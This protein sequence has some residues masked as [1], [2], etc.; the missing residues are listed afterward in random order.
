MFEIYLDV[1]EN[2]NLDTYRAN[3]VSSFLF[4][5]QCSQNNGHLIFSLL[6]VLKSYNVQRTN[7]LSISIF[8]YSDCDI[9]FLSKCLEYS[10]GPQKV[11]KIFL[12]EYVYRFQLR[13][14]FINHITNFINISHD[15]YLALHVFALN[16][17]TTRQ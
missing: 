9:Y 5:H 4:S 7:Q 1:T 6:Y 10:P 14:C 12:A 8:H 17:S 13:L 15:S 11:N 3:C 16:G 2:F